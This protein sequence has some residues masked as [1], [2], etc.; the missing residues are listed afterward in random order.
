MILFFEGKIIISTN[1][2]E[3]SVTID[4]IVYVIDSGYVKIKYFDYLRS[5]LI[6]CLLN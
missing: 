4:N 3:S 2:A 1:L 5:I 6:K